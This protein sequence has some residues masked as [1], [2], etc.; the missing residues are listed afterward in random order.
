MD[1]PLPPTAALPSNVSMVCL[2]VLPAW[3]L[4]VLPACLPC[5]LCSFLPCCP[6][7]SCLHGVFVCMLRCLPQPMGIGCWAGHSLRFAY[8]HVCL[9]PLSYF[10]ARLPVSCAITCRAPGYPYS[11]RTR[12]GLDAHLLVTIHIF[13]LQVH[14]DSRGGSSCGA[15]S[16]AP[17]DGLQPQ[18]AP[19]PTWHTTTGHSHPAA[20]ASAAAQ[21]ASLTLPFCQ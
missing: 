12:M 2:C 1:G 6:V 19:V 13:V 14:P 16:A 18:S 17:A 10:C 7:F 9:A 20:Q 8:L 4:R 5:S 3:L 11:H 21:V 15:S